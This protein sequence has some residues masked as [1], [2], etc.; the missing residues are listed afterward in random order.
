M[1][2]LQQGHQEIS[3]PRKQN[4]QSPVGADPDFASEIRLTGFTSRH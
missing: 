1:P 3:K 2:E 4:W